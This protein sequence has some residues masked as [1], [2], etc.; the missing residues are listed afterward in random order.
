MLLIGLELEDLH[1][2][3]SSVHVRPS[4]LTFPDLI[5]RA[6]DAQQFGEFCK[7]VF[8]TLYN[9]FLRSTVSFH[10][11]WFVQQSLVE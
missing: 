2:H 5:G 3:D 9:L 10:L 1:A 4:N 11:F 7:R 6:S 8:F